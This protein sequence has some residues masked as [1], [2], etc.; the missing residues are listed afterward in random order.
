ME[1][2]T[3]DFDTNGQSEQKKNATTKQCGRK[4]PYG[5]KGIDDTNFKSNTD[6]NDKKLS[7]ITKKNMSTLQPKKRNDMTNNQR[8]IWQKTSNVHQ[9]KPRDM[10]LNYKKLK[11][12][13]VH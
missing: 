5:N 13:E 8:K 10:G 1:R 7:M 2:K 4:P 6:E 11:I 12:N 3:S 9:Q